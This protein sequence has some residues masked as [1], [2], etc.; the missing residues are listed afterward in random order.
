MLF[1]PADFFN[2]YFSELDRLSIPY[3]VLHSYEELPNK[4]DSDI[5]YAVLTR[6]LPRLAGI[7]RRLAESCSAMPVESKTIT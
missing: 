4:I 2:L 6:D 1:S 5:D 3:V 7:Q